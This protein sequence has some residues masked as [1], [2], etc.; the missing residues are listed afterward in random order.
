MNGSCCVIDVGMI[1]PFLKVTPLMRRFSNKT[2]TFGVELEALLLRHVPD[3]ETSLIIHRGRSLC[4]GHESRF[5]E[6]R[7]VSQVLNWSD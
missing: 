3:S 5:G 4:A 7:T 2:Y 1:I 6:S